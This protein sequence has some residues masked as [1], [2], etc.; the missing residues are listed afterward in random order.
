MKLAGRVALVT[1]GGSWLGRA[2]A[3]TFAREGA[4]V[5]VNDLVESAAKE[6]VRELTGGG[7]LVLPG[8]PGWGTEV[9]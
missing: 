1:G 9:N 2:I 7:H 6:T 5:A 3:R 8:G 4:R